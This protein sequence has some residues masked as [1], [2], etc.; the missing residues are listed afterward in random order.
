MLNLDEKIKITDK[1]V[2]KTYGFAK[3]LHDSLP[4]A[5]FVGFTGTPID[6][7]LNVFGDI[8]E[9]YTMRDSIRDGITVRLVYDGRFAK[10]VL[11][12]EKLAE[13][14]QYVDCLPYFCC[15]EPD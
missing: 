9:K 8:V 2:K 12:P 15:I 13:I 5:T 7:T 14:E 6:E 3:Y 11:D 10:A 1:E 4:N